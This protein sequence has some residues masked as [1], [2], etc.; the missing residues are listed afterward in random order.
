MWYPHLTDHQWVLVRISNQFIRSSNP[1]HSHQLYRCLGTMNFRDFF[2]VQ[3]RSKR[4]QW[5]STFKAI[6]PSFWFMFL[7]GKP[8]LFQTFDLLRIWNTP[9]FQRCWHDMLIYYFLPTELISCDLSCWMF[10]FM[11]WNQLNCYPSNLNFIHV[12]IPQ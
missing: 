11:I 8:Y 4:P 6:Y 5:E 10:Y 1:L 9:F 7:V 2:Q 12:L 3:D